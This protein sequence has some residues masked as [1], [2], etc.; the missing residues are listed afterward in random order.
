[1]IGKIYFTLALIVLGSAGCNNNSADPE[2]TQTSSPSTTSTKDTAQKILPA[3][4]TTNKNQAPV[5]TN[6]TKPN[7][8]TSNSN[9]NP[10][11]GKPGH[12]CDISVGAPL[13][14]KPVAITQQTQP[15]NKTQPAV[16]TT[17]TTAPGMN[18]AHGEPGHRCDIAV[19]TPLSQPVKK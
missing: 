9:L 12:R 18:P 10:E 19:G 11:H 17:P 4:D 3:T 6:T 16:N 14:S 8:N 1:M 5:V 15:V 7:T 13:D 2:F